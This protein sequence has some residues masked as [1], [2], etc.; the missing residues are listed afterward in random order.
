M[1]EKKSCWSLIWG[2]SGQEFPGKQREKQPHGYLLARIHVLSGL[3]LNLQVTLKSLGD[4][5]H[6]LEPQDFWNSLAG[7]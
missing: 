4:T 1:E 7:K 6:S 3:C 2:T 5:R